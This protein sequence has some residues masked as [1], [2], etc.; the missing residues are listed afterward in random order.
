MIP[1]DRLTLSWVGK[2]KAL[3][4]TPED[5]YD[6]VNREDPRVTEIRLLHDV[7][8]VG[9]S[10]IDRTLENLLILGDSYDAARAL[11]RIP[12]FG[13]QY[14]GKVKLVYI[15]PPF[16][17][18]QAF[19]AYSDALQHSVWLTMMRDRLRVL[20]DLLEPTGTIWVHL[21][22]TEVHRCRC[23]MDDQFGPDNYVA[24]VVWQRTSAKSLARRTLGAMHEQILVYGASAEAKLNPQFVPLDED[25][26]RRRFSRSDARGVYDTGDLTAGDYRP[27]IDS[28]KP[29][30]EI[31]PS[32]KR[33]C[34]AVP[35]SVLAEI[36]LSPEV[37]KAMSM[38]E[39]LDALDA[40]GYI[41]HPDKPGGF[42]R[43]KKYLDRA[44]GRAVGDLWT[45]INVINSQA[46]ERTGFSTQKPEA[47]LRRILD[48][49]TRP[50]D[51][52]VDCFAGSGTTAAVAHKM[53]RRWV[54]VESVPT[55]VDTYALP[56]LSRVVSGLDRGG[57]SE[58]V[59]WRGGGGFRTLQVAD[60]ILEQRDGL[61]LL[62]ERA[63]NGE[64]AMAV[65]PQIGFTVV[66]D[67]PF[68]GRKGRQR[69]AV[70]DGVADEEAMRAVVSRL[71][72]GELAV[73]VAKAATHGA[74]AALTRLS[75]GSR[76]WHAPGDI[77]N[78]AGSR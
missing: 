38:R 51:I 44:K 75:P 43:Y 22:S 52:V 31:D 29:W 32:A 49:G 69:L 56:R 54:A 30:H 19:N 47:L 59:D 10:P 67:P 66:P 6:W 63:T 23:L 20:H 16:N 40:A 12:E 76:L 21:D 5:G 8:F 42:P 73:V 25:Y 77:L 61:F 34:W 45:D 58:A 62:S 2:D 65:C 39:K 9:E 3:I 70:L 68:V 33:R 53:G 24:T 26:R 74:E 55:V 15:D 36:G 35:R 11:T 17:T 7:Q 48:L 50:G 64:F 4:R 13:R 1:G 37:I 27:H 41:V 72:D 78:W 71:G 57:I 18:G 60:S 46:A 28:G 14:R